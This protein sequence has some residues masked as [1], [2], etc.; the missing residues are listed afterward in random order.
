LELQNLPQ[1]SSVGDFTNVGTHARYFTHG[2]GLS[3]HESRYSTKIPYTQ[4][5]YYVGTQI[6]SDLPLPKIVAIHHKTTLAQFE[7]GSLTM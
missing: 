5:N 4:I 2:S 1:N 6:S 3:A 7:T